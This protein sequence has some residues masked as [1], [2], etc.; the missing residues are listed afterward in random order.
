MICSRGSWS[1]STA[2]GMAKDTGVESFC[3]EVT[4]EQFTFYVGITLL[5]SIK[6]LEAK[7]TG[8]AS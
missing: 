6:A 8:Q 4:D 5:Q 2:K 1:L 3:S 7:A